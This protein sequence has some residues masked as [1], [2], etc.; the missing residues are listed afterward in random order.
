MVLG[1][2]KFISILP[3]KPYNFDFNHKDVFE[4][5]NTTFDNV[6]QLGQGKAENKTN[7]ASSAELGNEI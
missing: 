3:I 6:T 4:L 2:S 5:E 1:I 7:S